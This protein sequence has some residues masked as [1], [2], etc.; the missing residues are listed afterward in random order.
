[1]SWQY[2][3]PGSGQGPPTGAASGDLTGTYPSPTIGA[4]KVTGAKIAA[5]TITAANIANGTIT[6]AKLA[7]SFPYLL[8]QTG[9][10]STFSSPFVLD[11]TAITG[12]LY[13]WNGSA[14]VKAAALPT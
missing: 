11:N 12:D 10:P 4:A 2:P 1:M 3:L 5:T 9:V 7:A 13:G 14:Y 8:V 6:L